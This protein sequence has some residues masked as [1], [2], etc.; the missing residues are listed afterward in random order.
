MQCNG[1]DRIGGEK[2]GGRA[3]A[4]P[5]TNRHWGS[6]LPSGSYSRKDKGKGEIE[7]GKEGEK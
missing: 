7:E 5:V 3:T 6:Q 1:L 2:G 4:A